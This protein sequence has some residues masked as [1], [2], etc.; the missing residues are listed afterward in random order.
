MVA[1]RDG[2]E[3]VGRRIGPGAPCFIVAEAGVN[4]NGR[5]DL[6]ER[7]IDVAVAAGADA[8]KFQTFL[9]ERLVN[10]LRFT[11]IPNMPSA[12]RTAPSTR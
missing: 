3:I 10:G 11:K 2:I 9:A 4:H 5:L 8:V 6:A 12:N 7:L 1:G